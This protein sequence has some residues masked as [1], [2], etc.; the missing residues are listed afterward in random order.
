MKNLLLNTALLGMLAFGITGCVSTQEVRVDALSTGEGRGGTY[1]LA[2]STPGVEEGDLFFKE[3]SRFIEPALAN[4]RLYPAKDPNAA[5]YLI[6]VN[7]HLSDPM[8]ESESYSEP[9][10]METRG[11]YRA[12]RVPVVNSE[13]QIV[14]YSYSGYYMPGRIY[15]AGWIDN[16][17]QITVYDKVLELS[18]RKILGD[19]Q[20]SD[21][22]WAVSISMRSESTDY[23][24]ALPYMLVAADPYIGTRTEG[25]EIVK[26][27]LDSEEVQAYRTSMSNGR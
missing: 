9:I 18:A 19:D 15:N 2:S 6:E 7:A 12:V 24:A 26:I 14:R 25:E 10:Y 3:I 20:Y 5:D 13:G 17:R 4:K 16:E 23:R 1:L 11:H 8:T 27:K 22:I 21:E